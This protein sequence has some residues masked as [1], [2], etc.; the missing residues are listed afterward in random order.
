M[1][2]KLELNIVDICNRSCSFCPRGNGYAN[3]KAALTY[4]DSFI[5]KDRLKDYK[6]MI[7][8]SGFGEPLL[9][10]NFEKVISNVLPKTASRVTL[11]TNGDY[12]TP[13]KYEKIKI[14]GITHIKV[15][16]YDSD[17][18]N[19]FKSFIHDLDLSFNHYYELGPTNSVNR[20]EIFHKSGE[21]YDGFCFIPFYKLFV[22]Y[23]L[24]TY[25]CSND[26]TKSATTGN[27]K[28]QNLDQV[29]Y[30]DN[31]KKYRNLLK[32]GKRKIFP[33][34]NCSVCGTI[35]GEDYFNRFI[36]E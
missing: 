31:F 6:N 27:L 8:I 34:S 15:S 4:E 3:T 20:N 7:T 13:E 10:K 23:D 2:E 29:W 22:N 32:K 30:S 14:T 26:W 11:I 24:K 19:Y 33:C 12:L 36:G 9:H 17:T 35:E 21:L 25:L 1:I 5:L 28:H 16:L 18:S